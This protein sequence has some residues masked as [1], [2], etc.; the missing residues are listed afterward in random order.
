MNKLAIII[1]SIGL[2]IVQLHIVV[3]LKIII[4]YV[5]INRIYSKYLKILYIITKYNIKIYLNIS[6]DNIRNNRNCE[7]PHPIYKDGITSF[8]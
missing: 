6:Q 8:R 5:K 3:N 7:K 4:K 2:K 1:I